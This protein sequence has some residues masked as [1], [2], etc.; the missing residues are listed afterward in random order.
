MDAPDT[1]N[2]PPGDLFPHGCGPVRLRNRTLSRRI[3]FGAHTANMAEGGLPGDRHIGYYRERALGGAGMIVVEPVP[4]HLRRRRLIGLRFF[5]GRGPLG[6]LMLEVIE[7]VAQRRDLMRILIETSTELRQ[8]LFAQGGDF[9]AQARAG[10][11]DQLIDI[12]LRLLDGL[13]QFFVA[14]IELRNFCPEISLHVF[15]LGLLGYAAR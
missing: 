5:E 14:L 1:R 2:Q 8:F 7:A 11:A 10:L 3:T 13:L 9:L 6:E 12:D 15:Q 4:I